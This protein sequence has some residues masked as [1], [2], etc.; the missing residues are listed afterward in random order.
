MSGEWDKCGPFDVLR[1]SDFEDYYRFLVENR[2][3]SWSCES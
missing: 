2:V 3:G 1:G